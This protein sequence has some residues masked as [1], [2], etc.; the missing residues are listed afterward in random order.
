M[1]NVN[2]RAMIAALALLMPACKGFDNQ[3]SVAYEK[4]DQRF[5]ASWATSGKRVIP[6]K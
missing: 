1:M 2:R 6:T 4:N 5:E 3:F